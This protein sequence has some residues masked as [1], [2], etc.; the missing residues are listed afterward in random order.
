MRTLW[1]VL[2]MS[3]LVLAMTLP[4]TLVSS[5]DV[6][7]T[8][9]TSTVDGYKIV[10]R[11]KSNW[12]GSSVHKASY[13][14]WVKTDGSYNGAFQWSDANHWEF[15]SETGEL[16]FSKVKDPG[17]KLYA[18]Q[19]AN[20]PL[21][22]GHTLIK[23]DFYIPE[24]NFAGMQVDFFRKAGTTTFLN[25]YDTPETEGDH[26]G[27]Y[28][29]TTGTQG[30]DTSLGL[31]A[32]QGWNTLYMVMIFTPAL[33][34]NGD[35]IT[36]NG[37]VG[38]PWTTTATDIYYAISNEANPLPD[39]QAFCPEYMDSC[40]YYAHA[41]VNVGLD[42]AGMGGGFYIK[43]QNNTGSI[44]YRNV[45][46]HNLE[47]AKLYSVTY[48]G[49][50]DMM[51]FAPA[52]ANK[53]L[54][55]PETDVTFWVSELSDGSKGYYQ[56]GKTVRLSQNL[57]MT[58]ATADDLIVAELGVAVSAV[59]QTVLNSY[60]YVELNEKLATLE[61]KIA[62][63]EGAGADLGA[64]VYEN[65]IEL[66]DLLTGR[67]D[68]LVES[69]EELIYQA[70]IFSDSRN[71]TLAD[72]IDAYLLV[73]DGEYDA[74]YP[75]VT[76]AI[77]ALDAF[78]ATWNG[79]SE[80]WDVYEVEMMALQNADA[81]TDLGPILM[82][83]LNS[84]KTITENADGF[85]DFENDPECVMIKEAF[86]TNYLPKVLSDYYANESILA[87][88]E[89]ITEALEEYMLFK[90]VVYGQRERQEPPAEVTAMIDDYNAT[91]EAYNI[92]TAEAVALVASLQYMVVP[93]DVVVYYATG[94]KEALEALTAAE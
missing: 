93:T 3:L 23:F 9:P 94:I 54:V 87:K 84:V 49:Y 64:V 1:K 46:N 35:I 43:C 2:L 76:S 47:E 51:G 5:A 67:I 34:E 27:E 52:G 55:V 91:V 75:G 21:Q 70:E 81:A 63:Y 78:R 73:A 65:A 18:A 29:M 86:L 37:K 32:Q 62:D 85:G 61:E 77:Q 89:Y 72:R 68:G 57:Y 11:Y 83:L 44:T 13:G 69:H 14:H 79:I 12:I 22:P 15:N 6:T 28:R 71:Q 42:L 38:G 24:Q 82:A 7:P 39:T 20:N 48:E 50:D 8:S 92:E 74:T 90:T 88:Y 36:T 17:L 80:A 31:Y 40:S 26:V 25:I 66:Q 4:M 53:D 60:T 56:G 16:T 33:A 58:E 59:D 30:Y 19:I 10:E 45:E 41:N